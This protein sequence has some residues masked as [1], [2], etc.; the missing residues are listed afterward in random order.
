MLKCAGSSVVRIGGLKKSPKVAG[1]KVEGS[2]VRG[3]GRNAFSKLLQAIPKIDLS[4]YVLQY[5]L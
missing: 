2:K 4:T 1:S 5:V 3:E